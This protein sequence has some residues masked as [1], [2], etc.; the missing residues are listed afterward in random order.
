MGLS[1]LALCFDAKRQD[2]VEISPAART[3]PMPAQQPQLQPTQPRRPQHPQPSSSLQLDISS[4]NK[5]DA[6]YTS[7]IKHVQKK[8]NI[9]LAHQPLLWAM[10]C[11]AL[12]A[13]F[14]FSI[15]LA[16]MLLTSTWFLFCLDRVFPP[17]GTLFQRWQQLETRVHLRPLRLVCHG[18][19]HTTICG[20]KSLYRIVVMDKGFDVCI[21]LCSNPSQSMKAGLP[22]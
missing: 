3:T 19:N 2:G 13:M 9:Q 1:P 10:Q 14:N 7:H 11:A 21:C 22:G 5:N 17:P 16:L 4:C 6:S 18:W 8:R 15:L 12:L 20:P